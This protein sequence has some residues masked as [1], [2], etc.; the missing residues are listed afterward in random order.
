[1]TFAF[2]LVNKSNILIRFGGFLGFSQSE[3]F[4][5]KGIDLGR[6]CAGYTFAGASCFGGA[7]TWSACA[8]GTYTKSAYIGAGPYFACIRGTCIGIACV[9]GACVG[10]ASVVKRSEMHS[11]SFRILEVGDVGLKIRVGT[12]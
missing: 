12:G 2:L 6:A 4:N 3:S 7:C 9:R 5:A 1:M 10:S 8:G 11:Q